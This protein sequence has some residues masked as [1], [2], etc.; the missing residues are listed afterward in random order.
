MFRPNL[1]FKGEP[2]S[3]TSRT[4]HSLYLTFFALFLFHFPRDWGAG[5]HLGLRSASPCVEILGQIPSPPPYTTV[6][7]PP[8]LPPPPPMKRDAE[9]KRSVV[10]T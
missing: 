7:V 8:R 5:V 2:T 6:S 4:T 10:G 1:F 9:N 3:E